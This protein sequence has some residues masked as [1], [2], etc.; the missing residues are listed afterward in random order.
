MSSRSSL[1]PAAIARKFAPVDPIAVRRWVD[2]TCADQGVTVAVSDAATIARV[3]AL[4]GCTAGTSE[5][6]I[7]S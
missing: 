5:T 4:L 3:V 6:A 7:A 2:K 1:D